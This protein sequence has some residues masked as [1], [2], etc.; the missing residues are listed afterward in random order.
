MTIEWLSNDPSVVIGWAV[1]FIIIDFADRFDIIIE[2]DTY[3]I[4]LLAEE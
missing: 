3:V 4:N 1:I 2:P